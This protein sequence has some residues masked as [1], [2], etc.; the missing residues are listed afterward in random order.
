MS[1]S[2]TEQTLKQVFGFDS[3]RTGQ[4]QVI[5]A[6]LA[7]RSSLAIFPTSGGKSLCYQLPAL[8]LDGLTVVISPLIA[9]M[10]DQLDFL[11]S[12]NVPAARLDS[13]LNREE[14]LAVH[15]ALHANTLKLLYISPERLGNER[16]LRSLERRRISLLAVDEAHCISE[17]GHNFR[18]DYLKIAQLAKQLQVE[19]VLALTATATP[20]VARD[21]AAGFEVAD[22]DVVRTGFYR[23]NLNINVIPCQAIDRDELLLRQIKKR[24]PGPGV[25]YVTLQRTA[26]NVAAQ[27]TAA[28]FETRAYHA[29]MTA[30]DRHLV[31][32]AFMA[33]DQMIVVATIAF[34][35]GID[36]ADIRY[37]YHYNL[38]K[39]LENYSQEIGRAGRDG[40]TAVCEL[41]ACADDVVTLENFTYG[42][43]PTVEAV[44]G[45]VA[46]V[47][48]QEDLFD[49]SEYQLSTKYDMRILVVKTLLTYLELEGV[50]QATG[51][52]YSEYKFQPQRSSQQI[53]AQFN[54]ARAT[55]LK[56]VFRQ[57]RKGKTWFSLDVDET[58]RVIGEPRNRIVAAIGYLEERGDLIVEAAGVRKAFRMLR[59][60][61]DP[62]ALSESLVQRFQLREQQ[63]ILRVRQVLELAEHE[64]CWT[65]RLLD[66]F[67]ERRDDC[68][69]CGR[70]M[71]QPRQELVPAQYLPPTDQQRSEVAALLEEALPALQSAR[72]T[73][74]FLCGL[75]SPATTR[76]K[77][78]GHRLFG[79]FE[80]VPFHE[81]LQLVQSNGQ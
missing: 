57:A 18:P 2:Q 43:T 56:S 19:R 71:G 6:L 17:W 3:F 45:M 8:L 35:M 59:R 15:D 37:I 65:R 58:S 49:V 62:A 47:L 13:S 67:G 34:G 51:S 54:E 25:I 21:I 30:E 23:P 79:V 72:Q 22:Q 64:S 60:P 1:P 50:I 16:F 69:H 14:T 33:S 29:G 9:L 42:D 81:V 78:R 28:G 7:G 24:P 48:Q 70:C 4:R 27:L 26:E 55:F 39:S 32:E 38:P 12:H 77:L 68:G 53:F 75:S 76:T 61:E 80:S 40:K 63:D 31:Q 66:H 44:S 20:Q 74:R 41:L 52:F 10:K 5:D 36:K 46:E 11:T 73:T